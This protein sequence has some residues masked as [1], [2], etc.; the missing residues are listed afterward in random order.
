VSSQSTVTGVH[1]T[2][3]R[4]RHRRCVAP[5]HHFQSTPVQSTLV[6]LLAAGLLGDQAALGAVVVP[7][8]AQRLPGDHL[9]HVHSDK[10][11]D[12]HAV[13]AQVVFGKLGEN[14]RLAMCR[15]ESAKLLS[16]VLDLPWPVEGAEQPLHHVDG[17]D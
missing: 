16:D 4:H 14:A 7:Q 1:G 15:V 13:A 6:G 17:T 12:E 11:N 8:S 5:S 3:R 2:A 10:S 9:T